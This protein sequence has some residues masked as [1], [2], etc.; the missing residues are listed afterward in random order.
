MSICCIFWWSEIRHW[1]KN[2][3]LVGFGLEAHLVSPLK[4]SVVEKNAFPF[5]APANFQN[6]LLLFKGVFHGLHPGRWTAGTKKSPNCK[7]KSSSK[8]S[9]SGS[10]LIFQ[11]VIFLGAMSPSSRKLS[12][13]RRFLYQN[14]FS[15]MWPLI[16]LQKCAACYLVG[17]FSPTPLKDMLVKMGLSCPRF[18]VKIERYLKP[19]PSYWSRPVLRIDMF[20]VQYFFHMQHKKRMSRGSSDVSKKQLKNTAVTFPVWHLWRQRIHDMLV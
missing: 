17:G 20:H 11:G 19:P 14:N 2:I 12:D 6:E 18:G 5:G 10:M 3:K 9:F 13:P 16:P 8:S 4:K 15:L 1:E 7:G